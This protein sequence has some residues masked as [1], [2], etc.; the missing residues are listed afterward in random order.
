M[1]RKLLILFGLGIVM[2][3]AVA[4][5]IAFSSPG[6]SISLSLA[7]YT[8]D[9]WLIQRYR[10]GA[11]GQQRVALLRLVNQTAHAYF[12]SHGAIQLRTERGWVQDTNWVPPDVTLA[13]V[14]GPRR[15]AQIMFPVPAG[16]SSWRCGVDLLET[17]LQASPSVRLRAVDLLRRVAPNVQ[18]GF[19]VWSPEIAK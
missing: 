10:T 9:T 19:T 11:T 15:D 3:I 16:S 14:V 6:S 12:Y 5:R 1:S 18:S 8:N 7:G 2:L 4:A 17:H 13:S